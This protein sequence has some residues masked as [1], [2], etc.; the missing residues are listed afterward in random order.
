MYIYA[1]IT[2]NHPEAYCTE[3]ITVYILIF[4]FKSFAYMVSHFKIYSYLL[5]SNTILK[6]HYFYFKNSIL[7]LGTTEMEMHS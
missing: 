3:K 1:R 6:I 5:I 7:C 4:L 2:E